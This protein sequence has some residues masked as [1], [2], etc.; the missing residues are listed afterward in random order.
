MKNSAS[1]P[2][3]R[4]DGDVCFWC[5]VVGAVPLIAL[6]A[7]ALVAELICISTFYLFDACMRGAVR[8]ETWMKDDHHG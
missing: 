1:P 2:P 7:L 5:S 3:R 6:Y 4:A 8:I